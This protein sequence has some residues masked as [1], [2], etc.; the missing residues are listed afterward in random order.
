MSKLKPNKKGQGF[1]SVIIAVIVIAVIS[2]SIYAA[3]SNAI[4]LQKYKQKS[5]HA[6]ILCESELDKYKNQLTIKNGDQNYDITIDK[7]IYHVSVHVNSKDNNRKDISVT[8]T[9]NHNNVDYQEQ[10]SVERSD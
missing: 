8:I 4:I 2:T 1:M 3:I 9:Y 10:L 7:E 5:F 6:L